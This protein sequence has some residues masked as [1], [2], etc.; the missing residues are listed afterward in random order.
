VSV[1]SVEGSAKDGVNEHASRRVWSQTL[2]WMC[3][4]LDAYFILTSRAAWETWRSRRWAGTARIDSSGSA[5]TCG[6]LSAKVAEVLSYWVEN[7]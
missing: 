5:N 3:G 1:T 2:C 7:L 4:A 6:S